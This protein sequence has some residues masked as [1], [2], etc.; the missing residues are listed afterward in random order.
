MWWFV[1]RSEY[2]YGRKNEGNVC[3]D[4]VFFF[5]LWYHTEIFIDMLRIENRY[6]QIEIAKERTHAI[7]ICGY[8]IWYIV[9]IFAWHNT[10]APATIKYNSNIVCI[11]FVFNSFSINN[12]KFAIGMECFVGVSVS[13]SFISW[14]NAFALKPKW[15]RQYFMFYFDDW[16]LCVHMYSIT[17]ENINFSFLCRKC[18]HL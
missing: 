9:C 10:L 18:Y 1:M 11:D 4:S 3:D 8:T 14:A 17:Y 16:I 6:L 15:I 7:S 2:P 5:L 13:V 12:H